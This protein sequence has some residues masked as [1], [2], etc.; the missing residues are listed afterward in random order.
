MMKCTS[1]M[2]PM[3]AMV[4][5]AALMMACGG[6]EPEAS[7]EGISEAL[8]LED[9]GYDM[10]DEMPAF[11]LLDL[12]D[13]DVDVSGLDTP[14]EG[15]LEAFLG[16]QP[17]SK[18]LPPPCPHGYLK[19]VWKR[20]NPNKSLGVY[21]GKWVT[22]NGKVEGWLKGVF[23]MN[24]L[25]HGVF[26]GKYID[27]TGKFKGLLKGY[28]GNG[29]FR[30]R[31]HGKSGGIGELRGVYGQNVFK[32][33]WVSYCNAKCNS[34]CKP[35][36]V[37]APYACF[38]VPAKLPPCQKGK[39]PTGMKCD[40]CPKPAVC[41]LPNAKCPAVCGAPVCKPLPKPQPAK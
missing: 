31:Y 34:V 19:G 25:G 24:K 37:R 2:L 18:K 12:D 15:G 7:V 33:K 10:Q 22:A 6:L 5:A 35:G 13:L 28:Y 40:P 32:G 23:G 8:E 38:C 26:F 14:E 9:G 36:H 21:K 41:L 1:K 4:A 11:G 29:F 16:V 17:S 39:C 3:V 27:K 30:G 20:L